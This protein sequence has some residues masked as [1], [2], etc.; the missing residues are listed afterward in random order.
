MEKYRRQKCGAIDSRLLREMKEAAGAFRRS[1]GAKR[2]AAL[3]GYVTALHHFTQVALQRL[4]QVR[5]TVT[6]HPGAAAAEA[7]TS[8]GC[9]GIA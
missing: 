5:Y 6:Q 9:L 4:P 1:R 2:L 3:D 7:P 8:D